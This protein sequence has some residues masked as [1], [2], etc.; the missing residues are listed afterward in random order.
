MTFILQ[1]KKKWQ[2]EFKVTKQKQ[3]NQE[4][5]KLNSVVNCLDNKIQNLIT[6]LLDYMFPQGEVFFKVI[7]FNSMV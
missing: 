3:T 2:N 5:P 6:K 7:C 4:G 1:M